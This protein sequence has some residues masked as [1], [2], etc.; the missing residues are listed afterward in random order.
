[1]LV[2]TW[3]WCAV[4]A[5]PWMQRCQPGRGA[6]RRAAGAPRY[7]GL[8]RAPP[9]N[10]GRKQVQAERGRSG[11]FAP[12]VSGNPAGRPKGARNR[13]TQACFDLLADS[14]EAIIAKAVRMAKS[15][16][17]VAL[18]LCIERLLPARVARDRAVSL[19]VPA[20]TKAADLVAAAGAVISKAAA[21][22]MSLSEAREFMALLE[23]QRRAIETQ[24]LA[25][26]VELLERSGPEGPKGPLGFAPGG[27]G[28]ADP[29]DLAVRVRRLE[30]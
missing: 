27:D 18:R 16:D 1:M 6:S 13:V 29:P 17:G 7:P 8:V 9:E 25:V 12:G 5:V 23:L 30:P 26:R 4:E 21:G 10:T 19:E 22:E 20:I 2:W 11:T 14:S 3:R 24:E 15:G 28:A